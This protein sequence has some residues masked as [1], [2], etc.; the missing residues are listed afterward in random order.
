LVDADRVKR[1]LP[2]LLLDGST[3]TKKGWKAF[4]RSRYRLDRFKGKH[5][6]RFNTLINKVIADLN[7]LEKPF[8]TD[9]FLFILIYS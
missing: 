3:N 8:L 6:E 5:P 7:E 9:F 1:K 2:S 4:M